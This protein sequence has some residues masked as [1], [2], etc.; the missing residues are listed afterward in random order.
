MQ[1]PELVCNAFMFRFIIMLKYLF[2]NNHQMHRVKRKFGAHLD[3]IWQLYT[4][5]NQFDWRSLDC[6][7][8]MANHRNYCRIQYYIF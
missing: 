4:N 3:Q 7:H 1:H 6:I 5:K 8:L 2:E